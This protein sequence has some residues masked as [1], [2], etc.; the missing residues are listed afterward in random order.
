MASSA[1]LLSIR[2][3]KFGHL[4]SAW[5]SVAQPDRAAD[6]GTSLTPMKRAK[7]HGFCY[8]ILSVWLSSPPSRQIASSSPNAVATR[9]FSYQA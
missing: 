2:Q 8:G 3:S 6:F 5:V 9:V 1:A 4:K 7:N